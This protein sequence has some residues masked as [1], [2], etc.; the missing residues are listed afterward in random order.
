MTDSDVELTHNSH[1]EAMGSRPAM[2]HTTSV[3]RSGALMHVRPLALAL[4][5]VAQNSQRQVVELAQQ[6]QHHDDSKA[7]PC[8]LQ[9]RTHK[10]INS[11]KVQLTALA[12]ATKVPS[13]MARCDTR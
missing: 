7:M 4:G 11:C 10:A 8:N 9:A 12:L 3:C 2:W 6:A 13:A 5:V 1:L